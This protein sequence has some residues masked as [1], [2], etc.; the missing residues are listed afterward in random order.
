M[1]VLTRLFGKFNKK[2]FGS[3]LIGV[4]ATIG[5][6]LYS[7]YCSS[8][9]PSSPSKA[10]QEQK[11]DNAKV[12]NSTS[13]KVSTENLEKISV[14]NNKS[15]FIE[16]S[17]VVSFIPDGD[18][19]HFSDGRKVRLLGINCP[20]IYHDQNINQLCAI[21]AKELI[22]KLIEKKKIII[23]YS[24][25]N[26][27]DQYQRILADVYAGEEWLNLR[28]VEEGL[29]FVYT[30]SDRNL[31][32]QLYVAETEAQNA[33]KGIWGK[34]NDIELFKKYE[35]KYKDGDLVHWLE[36][37]V[38]VAGVV[39]TARMNKGAFVLNIVTPEGASIRASLSKKNFLHFPNLR[40]ENY[41]GKSIYLIG[42][43]SLY[44]GNA[45]LVFRYPTEV[46][47]YNEIK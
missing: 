15:D 31:D 47:L 35:P 1:N 40:E 44:R 26:A 29:A 18:T 41:K 11:R 21:E 39:H 16:E 28:M 46:Y 4:L 30:T 42:R 25:K 10:K 32:S 12:V 38:L 17:G 43:V 22:M 23:K 34:V 24:K 14:E 9:Q 27:V 13:K 2:S 7:R 8:S 36:K 33:K 5:M 20:E 19:F 6:A 37:T 45:E 3:L